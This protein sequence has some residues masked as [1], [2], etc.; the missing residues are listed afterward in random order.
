MSVS[1]QWLS[2]S[3]HWV[4]SDQ[5]VPVTNSQ[6]RKSTGNDKHEVEA[7]RFGAALLMPASLVGKEIR[8]QG[9]DLDDEDA[10]VFLAKRFRV[11]TVAMTYRLNALGLL[12]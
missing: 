1:K 7:N 9:L 5:I 12:R 8:K 2:A 10:Q 4:S 3:P 6:N 11:S